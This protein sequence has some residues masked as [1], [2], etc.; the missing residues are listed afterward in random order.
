MGLIH[1]DYEKEAREW[2]KNW[3]SGFNYKPHGTLQAEIHLS[4][5]DTKSSVWG[6][7]SGKSVALT[8]EAV[9]AIDEASKTRF[10]APDG[11]DKTSTLVPG[12]HI[13]ICGPTNALLRQVIE[14]FEMVIPQHMFLKEHEPADWEKTG[15]DRR[16]IT[17]EDRR[18]TMRLRMRDKNMRIARGVVRPDVK[19]EMKSAE[20]KAGMQSARIDFLGITEAQD[21]PERAY[22]DALPTLAGGGRLGRLFVE[23]IAPTSSQHWSA[24]L[25]KECLSDRSGRS[26]AFRLTTFDN[27]LLGE[28]ELQRVMDARNRMTRSEW[29]RMYLAELPGREGAFFGNIQGCATAKELE[30]PLPGRRYVCGVDLGR[31]VD[32]TVMLVM[33]VE[34][35]EAVHAVTFSEGEPYTYQLDVLEEMNERWRFDFINAD[36]TGM[37]GDALF[38]QMQMR[39]L[40]AEGIVMSA[41]EKSDVYN[42]L[43]VALEQGTTAFPAHWD[44]LVEQLGAVKIR[45]TGYGIR[46]F[47]SEGNLHDDWVDAFALALRGCNEPNLDTSSALGD[48]FVVPHSKLGARR[49]I[50][51]KPTIRR[52]YENALEEFQ[53]RMDA[54]GV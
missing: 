22:N 24:R 52:R 43:A 31:L 20:S 39:G 54:A 34:T 14:Y 50:V 36:K 35:R 49:E 45:A 40:P 28:R 37:G 5:A 51:K 23:G 6:R 21:V 53:M 38:E 11:S 10:I 12:V 32:D 9:M 1:G 15:R 48:G 19:I 44:M 2:L 42:R 46:H 29:R 7:G 27:P 25:F 4:R 26:D 41:R 13:W 30:T 8:A 47:E 33:D 18:M 3:P 17:G 16:G